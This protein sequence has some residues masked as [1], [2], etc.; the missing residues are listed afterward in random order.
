MTS[1]T[2]PKARSLLQMAADHA[3]TSFD[4]SNL[5]N[6]LA[7]CEDCREYAQNLTALQDN[8]RR[9]THERWSQTNI[10]ISAREI[11]ARAI[12]YNFLTF[13]KFAAATIILA[14][15]FIMTTNFSGMAGDI[16]AAVGSSSI[17]PEWPILTP[18]PA[19]QKTAS[20]LATAQCNEITYLVQENDTIEGIAARHS[21]SVDIIRQRNGLSTNALSVNTVLTLPF[22]EQMPADSTA[23]PTL[24]STATP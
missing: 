14:F 18:T 16:P 10:K 23:T 20:D 7:E 11:K 6:H 3:L 19:A 8:L 24:T 17:T 13:G 1:I 15:M 4:A 2:H 22:C 9:I 21:V 12:R 5:G